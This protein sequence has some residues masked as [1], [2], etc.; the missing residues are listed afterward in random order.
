MRPFCS[1][2]RL[3]D[4][5]VEYRARCAPWEALAIQAISC[6]VTGGVTLYP[7]GRREK[8]P[9]SPEIQKILDVCDEAR[10]TIARDI[11]NRAAAAYTPE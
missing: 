6:S 3:G 2:E 9:F 5:I 11:G 1:P 8:R 4:L 10:A 7:D